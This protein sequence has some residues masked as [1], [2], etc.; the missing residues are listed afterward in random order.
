MKRWVGIRHV[1]YLYHA[2]LLA[3]WAALWEPHGYLVQ[4]SDYDYLSAIWEG[5][6]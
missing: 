5:K 1:R 2:W 3:R 6:A 4:P